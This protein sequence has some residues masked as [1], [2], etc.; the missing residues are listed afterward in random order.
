MQRNNPPLNNNEN[1]KHVVARKGRDNRFMY[2]TVAT[3]HAI[4]PKK[5][6][7]ANK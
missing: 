3:A 1:V 5:S 4:F 7:P 2:I 6:S